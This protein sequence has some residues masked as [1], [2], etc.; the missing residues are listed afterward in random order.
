MIAILFSVLFAIMGI[1][2]LLLAFFTL[3]A[4]GLGHGPGKTE[5]R[6]IRLSVLFGLAF[7]SLA[8]WLSGVGQ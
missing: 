7:L 5:K 2:C 1:L 6:V 4:S 8:C 3:A